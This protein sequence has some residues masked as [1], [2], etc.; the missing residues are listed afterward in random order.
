MTGRMAVAILSLAGMLLAVPPAVHGEEMPG[1]GHIDYFGYSDC[2]LLENEHARVILAEHGGRVLEYSWKKLNAIYL[3]P[4]H[5]GWVYDPDK[6]VIDPSGGR[7]DIGPEMVI[8][9]HVDLWAGRWHAEII[10]P[11]AARLTSVDDE[12]TG[13]RL[14]REFV[15][16]EST[17]HLAFTQ[18]IHNISEVETEWCH[19]GRTFALGRGICVI[20]L[21]EHFNRFPNKYLVYGPGPVMNYAPE[22]PNIR[23]RDGYLEIIDTPIEP[24]IA[25]DSYAVW[26][27]YL[28]TNDLMFVK[29]FPTYPDRMYNDMAA[30]TVVMWYFKDLLCEL[31][32]IGPKE[33]LAPGQSASF[34][35]DWWLL[36]YT[37]PDTRTEVDLAN[38]AAVVSQG[39]VG[40]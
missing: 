5:A 25:I 21:G 11:R 37:F 23:V 19:W 36:P 38:V 18:T 16:D 32:P 6:P 20:P 9:S 28:M 24:M 22:D 17:S 4:E 1:T 14:V 7:S 34:T 29:R 2:I 13:T 3:D 10:G 30:F 8:P 26:F 40:D 39:A 15:L 33:R 35:E 31:E 12:A 27:S